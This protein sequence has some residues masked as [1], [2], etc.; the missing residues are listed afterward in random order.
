MLPRLRSLH[1]A[2]VLHRLAGRL[3]G[4]VL[5]KNSRRNG[6]QGF[7]G[8][9]HQ[10]KTVGAKPSSP[11]TDNTSVPGASIDKDDTTPKSR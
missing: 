2:F 11:D 3:A 10:R 1:R 6:D 9:E 8:A 7:S 4:R 5:S